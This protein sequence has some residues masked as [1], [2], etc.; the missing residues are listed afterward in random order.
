[1]DGRDKINLFVRLSNKVNDICDCNH[2]P[3]TLRKLPADQ[4]PVHKLDYNSSGD[5][6][7]LKSSACCNGRLQTPDFVW[8]GL[9]TEYALNMQHRTVSGGGSR[10]LQGS[11]ACE[12]IKPACPF[13]GPGACTTAGC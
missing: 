6:S 11:F 13:V 5:S 4:G 1:M 9:H 2:F 12:A 10:S 8:G 7:T 3:T